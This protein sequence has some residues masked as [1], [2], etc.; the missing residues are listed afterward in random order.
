MNEFGK[1]PKRVSNLLFQVTD[2]HWVGTMFLL[3]MVDGERGNCISDREKRFPD[4]EKQF[5]DS[6][7]SN[8]PAF[9]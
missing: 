9:P 8:A 7:S 6:R 3:P 2:T 1:S 5:L 4:P